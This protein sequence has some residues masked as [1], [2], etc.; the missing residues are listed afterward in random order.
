AQPHHDPLCARRLRE[1]RLQF[2][3]AKTAEVRCRPDVGIEHAG[4][5]T[6][7][8]PHA[9][10][11]ATPVAGYRE[12]RLHRARVEAVRER[13]RVSSERRFVEE[14]LRAKLDRGAW[15]PPRHLHG[16]AL[17]RAGLAV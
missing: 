11:V 14:S 15:T 2:G 1:L 9:P 5:A 8:P 10:S 16:A 12:E 6:Q 17:P 7:S 13:L 3:E 4:A